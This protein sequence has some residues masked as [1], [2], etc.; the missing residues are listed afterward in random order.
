[1]RW[2]IAQFY[3]SAT[4][5]QIETLSRRHTIT[6]LRQRQEI[7]E[8]VSVWREGVDISAFATIHRLAIRAVVVVAPN[9]GETEIYKFN[10]CWTARS[11]L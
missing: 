6:D 5:E 1:M 3:S 4:N 9:R 2:E 7:I 11:Q 10:R 8:E